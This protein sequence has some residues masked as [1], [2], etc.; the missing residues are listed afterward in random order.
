MSDSRSCKG[1]HLPSAKEQERFFHPARVLTPIFTVSQV[2]Y[3]SKV[4]SGHHGE[5][6]LF[7]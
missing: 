3:A 5:D 7:T 4:E 2:N 6:C 1:S